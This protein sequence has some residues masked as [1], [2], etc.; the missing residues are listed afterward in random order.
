MMKTLQ[1]MAL[2]ILVGCSGTPLSPQLTAEEIEEQFKKKKDDFQ[3]CYREYTA[4]MPVAISLKARFRIE[5]SGV[6]KDVDLKT[7]K[8]PEISA[9]RGCVTT[10]IKK[11]G[12]RQPARAQW[13]LKVF[14]FK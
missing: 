5:V 10:I 12:F 2:L 3:E 6:I 1:V 14:H 8:G 13:A 7:E 9:L 4:Y 11:L